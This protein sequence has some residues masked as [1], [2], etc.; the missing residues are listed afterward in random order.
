MGTKRTDEFRADAVRIALTS[1]LT[2]KQVASDLGVGLSTLNKWVTAH[3][4][5]DVVSDKDLVLARENERLRRENR[6]R[7]EE[8]DI[9]KK[10]TA[11]FARQRQRADMV[12]LAHIKEQSRLSLGSYGRPRMTEELKELGLNVGHRRAGRLMRENGI[13]VERS[14]KYKVTTDSNHAFNIA[15]SLLNQDFRSD[16]PNQKWAGDISYVWTRE[17]WLYLAVILD[18][19][20]AAGD[21]LGREQSH[22]TRPGDPCV[23]DGG[24]VATAAQGLHPS[25]GS[26]KP[27]LLP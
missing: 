8:R 13:R 4:H 17:G 11:F 6:I 2:R 1:G 23:E 3:R 9:L 14:K 21:R 19:H 18:L 20:S 5:T 24:R 15:P 27:I 10:A 16:Q 26:W 25:Y 22:E 12:V 7:K